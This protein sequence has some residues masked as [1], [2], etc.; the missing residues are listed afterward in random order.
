MEMQKREAPVCS[1][2]ESDV[3]NLDF[4]IDVE[5]RSA[6]M[7]RAFSKDPLRNTEYF[8]RKMQLATKHDPFGYSGGLQRFVLQHRAVKKIRL[9][10]IESGIRLPYPTCQFIFLNKEGE[11][12]SKITAHE[13]SNYK[14]FF[15]MEIDGLMVSVQ[16][17]RFN[18]RDKQGTYHYLPFLAI[19]PDKL[20]RQTDP[21]HKSMAKAVSLI[22]PV[23]SFLLGLANKKYSLVV[24]G[25]LYQ[26]NALPPKPALEGDVFK[27]IK[28]T[29]NNEKV[30]RE[31]LGGT[32]ASPREHARIGH[33]RTLRSGKVIWIDSHVVNKGKTAGRVYK[34]YLIVDPVNNL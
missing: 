29:E 26:V 32:H 2:G 18:N 30:K 22:E 15:T 7:V 17:N 14:L 5:S 34:D 12:D 20:I 13:L 11:Q 10:K 6:T 23:M 27:V 1:I 28:Y 25:E 33:N 4:D 3:R 19:K 31:Y 21:R 9:E 24:E 8:N 16:I